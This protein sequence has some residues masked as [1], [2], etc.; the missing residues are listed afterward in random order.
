MGGVQ[1]HTHL[2]DVFEFVNDLADDRFGV[3]VF[4]VRSMRLA[5]L[6]PWT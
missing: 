5:P 1:I 2:V 6:R 4:G 3:L